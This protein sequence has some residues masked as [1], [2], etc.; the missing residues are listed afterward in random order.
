MEDKKSFFENLIYNE[1]KDSA[2]PIAIIR[3]KYQGLDI[4]FGVNFNEINRR[5]I[6][7]QIKKYGHQLDPYISK[8]RSSDFVDFSKKKSRATQREYAFRK[9]FF[10]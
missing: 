6:N 3:Q 8:M 7:Y 4:K 9:R 2:V 10:K 5:K 1:Y